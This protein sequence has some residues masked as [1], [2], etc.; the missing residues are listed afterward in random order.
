VTAEPIDLLPDLVGLGV[1]LRAAGLVVG[2]G[3]QRAF[4]LAVARLDPRDRDDLYWAGRACLVNRATDVAA[5]DSVFTAWFGGGRSSVTVAGIPPT[6]RGVATAG[7]RIDGPPRAAR[8][9]LDDHAG[10]IASPVEALRHKD[11]A[12]CTDDERAQIARILARLALTAPQRRSRRHRRTPSGRRP[13]L[14]RAL[15]DIVG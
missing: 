15:R 14:R 6:G 5:Y 12:V 11:F 4:A 13:D 9:A 3:Q 8:V 10:L 2:T 1:A 7:V